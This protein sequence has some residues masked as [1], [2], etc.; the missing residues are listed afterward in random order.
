[1]ANLLGAGSSPYVEKIGRT[2]ACVLDDVHGAH[3]QSR[4]VH[5][6]AYGSIQ[7]DI[8]QPIFGCFD[9][10]RVLFSEV[11][12]LPDL[13]VAEQSVVIEGHLGVERQQ[14]PVLC[15]YEGVDLGKRC[16]GGFK[17]AVQRHHERGGLLDAA[18]RQSQAKG[19]LPRLKSLQAR[20]RTDGLAQ[21]QLGSL[22]RHLLNLHAPGGARH[23]DR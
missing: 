22:F 4:P 9:L 11:A 23:E 3:R 1:M 5:H 12:Q 15:Q 13:L 7:F 16:V 19:E 8:V 17:S 18:R 21:N 6:A 2:P 14:P 20:A 10:E